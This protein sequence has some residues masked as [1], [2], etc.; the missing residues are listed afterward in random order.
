MKDAQVQGLIISF[1]V[2]FIQQSV[3][4]GFIGA[5]PGIIAY[6]LLGLLLGRAHYLEELEMRDREA[7]E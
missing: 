3:E 2:L 5:P 4:L 7:Y 6:V 1:I